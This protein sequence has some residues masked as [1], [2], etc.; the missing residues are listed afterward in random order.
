[1]GANAGAAFG[2]DIDTNGDEYGDEHDVCDSS[3]SLAEAAGILRWERL[4]GR[5]LACA[6]ACK[7]KLT[8]H[9]LQAYLAFSEGCNARLTWLSTKV[10]AAMPA[11]AAPHASPLVTYT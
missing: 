7:I 1:M 6:V 2:I 9:V 10:L 5:L 11:R 3:T 4:V 8:L